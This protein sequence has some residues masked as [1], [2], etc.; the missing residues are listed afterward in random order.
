MKRDSQIFNLIADER[1]RQL[2]GIELIPAESIVSDQFVERVKA[3]FV[4][5]HELSY[6]TGV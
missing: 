3:H 2:T 5:L 4:F 6:H 1:A